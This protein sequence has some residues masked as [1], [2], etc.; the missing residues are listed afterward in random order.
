VVLTNSSATFDTCNVVG[1]TGVAGMAPG[2]GQNGLRL[3][4]SHVFLSHCTIAG[5]TG[6]T[7][8]G[9]F[10]PGGQGGYAVSGDA[11]SLLV[12]VGPGAI[13]GG[14]DGGP[15]G[16]P[17]GPQDPAIVGL[18][19]ANM[20][21]GPSIA[22][23]PVQPVTTIAEPPQL[24]SPLTLPLGTNVAISVGNAANQFVLLGIDTAHDL[25]ALPVIEMPFVLSTAASLYA[26]APPSP[27]SPTSFSL[28]VPPA[29]WLA[30]VFVYWQ[31]VTVAN[32][33]TIQFSNGGY[34]RIQ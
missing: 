12:A 2:P 24:V 14:F 6:G 3:Q 30:N 33:G 32:D 27:T 1:I 19:P 15:L 29:P 10:L 31:A 17:H 20:R 4:Q 7:F 9:S 13:T 34:G 28:F 16:S 22:V 21:L 25:I 18:P 5:G 8:T 11:A 23:T 26:F